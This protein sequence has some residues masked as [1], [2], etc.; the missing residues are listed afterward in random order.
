MECEIYKECNVLTNLEPNFIII[1]T[2]GNKQLKNLG[3]A[4]VKLQFN[5]DGSQVEVPFVVVDNL[6]HYDLIFG[7][8]AIQ[9][10]NISLN[11]T[12]GEAIV[13]DQSYQL[14]PNF[15]IKTSEIRSTSEVK[16]SPGHDK[17][18]KLNVDH[19]VFQ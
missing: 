5:Q 11:F 19:I 7:M 18:I 6:S 15:Y 17:V 9:Q 16:I 8:P 2:I 13:A 1:Q 3:S 4:K 14:N 12:K 10:L